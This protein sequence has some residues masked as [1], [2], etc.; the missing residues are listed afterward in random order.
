MTKRSRC[1]FSA[2]IQKVSYYQ[3]SNILKSFVVMLTF[4]PRTEALQK[5]EANRHFS[6][7]QEDNQ[8]K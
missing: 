5:L 4:G 6:A 2:K 7:L 1:H 3:Q 8:P